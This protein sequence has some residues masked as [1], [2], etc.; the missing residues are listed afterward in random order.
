MVVSM[1]YYSEFIFFF[2]A[3]SPGKKKPMKVSVAS[4]A[5]KAAAVSVDV[6]K[7]KQVN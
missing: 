3:V 6:R 1:C 2:S 4:S 5:A 7:K